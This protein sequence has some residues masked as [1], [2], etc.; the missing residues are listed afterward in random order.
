VLNAPPH[1]SKNKSHH[2]VAAENIHTLNKKPIQRK[3]VEINKEKER[4]RESV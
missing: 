3:R 4:E 2:T 1:Y